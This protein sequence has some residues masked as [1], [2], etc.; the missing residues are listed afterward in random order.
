MNPGP[1]GMTHSETER[2]DRKGD[3]IQRRENSA[4]GRERK[5]KM[6]HK[7]TFCDM[8]QPCEGEEK[9]K[10]TTTFNVESYK[11]YNVM[12]GGENPG[13]CTLF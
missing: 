11:A 1:G 10:L 9:M 5:K 3:I 6:P 12:T 13:C 7:I 4:S 2:I 8:V